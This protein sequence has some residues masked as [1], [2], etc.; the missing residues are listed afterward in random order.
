MSC[1]MGEPGGFNSSAEGV[2]L[3]SK[4]KSLNLLKKI[5]NKRKQSLT[6]I[7]AERL[8]ESI[9]RREL[10]L[11]EALSEEKIAVAMGVSRT[12]VREALTIL[13]MQ[14][15]ISILPR[16]GSF[17]F[18]PDREDLKALV[19]YRLQLELLA[20]GLAL[21]RAPAAA[22]KDLVKVIAVMEKAR[23]ADDALAYAKAD[24]QFHQVLFERCG[25][26]FFMDAFEIISGR[27][28]ALRSHLSA[29]LGLHRNR[30][31]LEHLKIAEAFDTKD[32]QTLREVLVRHIAAMEP[33]YANALRLISEGRDPSELAVSRGE[34]ALT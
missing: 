13:Q 15:L 4:D 14:G 29:P 18:K 27:V 32:S 30:T 26:Y 12:P 8:K 28:A 9:L 21:E 16:R 20:A 6:A 22:H 23:A 17:V 31:H 3:V 34:S 1:W 11:G 25:N 2:A 33:N 19:E 7:V 24:S 10:T 5:P